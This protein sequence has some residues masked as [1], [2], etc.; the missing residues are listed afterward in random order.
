MDSPEN[1][2]TKEL[3]DK[4]LISEEQFS[5]IKA[6]RS[7]GI[8]SLHNELLFLIYL[9]VLLF[10]GG[11]GILIYQNID[12]IGHTVIL[13]LLFGIAAGCFWLCF[14]KATGFSKQETVFESPVYDYLVLLGTLLS[15]IFVGYL[16]FQYQAL[17]SGFSLA[18]F[19]SAAIAFAA[20]YYFDNRSALTIGITGLAAFIGITI[21]PQA[22]IDNEIYTTDAL[23][24]YGLG[25]G[26]A[27]IVWAEYCEKADLK[28]HFGLV[29][30]TFAL[31]LVGLCSIKG[32]TE[33]YWY[34]YIPA[35]AAS[36]YYFYKKSYNIQAISIFVFTLI[37]GYIGV[38]ILA[39]RIL[40]YIRLDEFFSLLIILFP[41]YIIGSIVLFIRA[42]KQFNKQKDDSNR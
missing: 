25:L 5:A 41:V 30:L 14:K 10:T 15:C 6:Y 21:T 11:A 18:A 34:L 8:F 40:N 1:R 28:K 27:L 3:F 17:G 31:H 38:N 12:T 4:N 36:T 29:F 2:A 23:S 37:Y 33:D 19:V 22:V 26:M 9:S 24:Y 32:M 35:L 20:A 13:A 7:L 42:I 39:T 16:Q